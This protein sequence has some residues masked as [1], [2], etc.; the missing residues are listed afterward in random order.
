MLIVPRTVPIT[1]ILIYYINPDNWKEFSI[2]KRNVIKQL[3]QTEELC[4]R[5][6]LER[7]LGKVSQ[8]LK[9]PKSPK[10]NVKITINNES[11]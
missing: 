3:I 7:Y 1:H 11:L 10:S 8:S 6:A 2:M 9:C 5:D 4:P